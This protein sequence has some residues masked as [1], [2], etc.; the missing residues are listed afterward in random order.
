MIR[1]TFRSHTTPAKVALRAAL[2][3]GASTL[4]FRAQPAESPDSGPKSAKIDF[5]HSRGF[6]S[7]PFQLA[8]GDAAIPGEIRF[9]TDGSSPNPTNGT[10]YQKPIPVQ[11]TAVVRA[12]VVTQDGRVSRPQ[13]HT[14]LFPADILR[15][16]PDGLP[17]EGWPI[18]WGNNV[19]DYGMDPAV[20]DDPRYR[21]EVERALKSLPTISLVMDLADLFDA[22]TGIYANGQQGGRDWERPASVELIYPDGRKGFQEECGVRIR[23]GFSSGPFNP[24]HAFRLFFRREYG[25]GKLKYPMFGLDAAAEFDGF[26]MRCAQNYSWNIG[27]DARGLFVRDQFNRDLQRAMGQPAAR[28]DFYHL[29]LNGQY[30]GL[31]NSCE[32]PEASFAASYFGGSKEDYDVIKTAGVGGGPGAMALEATDGTMDRWRRL[33]EAASAD[34]SDNA[35][36]FKLLG[37]KPDGSPDPDG[38]ALLDPA[39]LIDYLLVIWFGGNLDA[40]VSRFAGNRAPNNW[41]AVSRRSPGD[42]F[43]FFIW[44]AE[45]TLLDVEEDRAGPFA[46]GGE[47]ADSS[48]PQWLFQRCV[49]N[50]EFRQLLA[51]R[52][53]QHFSPGGVLS[54]NFTI[55]L[56]KKHAETI[57]QAVICESARWGDVSGG[58]GFGAGDPSRRMRQG[59]D[60]EPRPV[61]RTRDA[62][63]RAEVD[64]QLQ[65]Y[66]PRR[67]DIVLFQLWRQGYVSDLQPPTFSAPAG[68]LAAGDALELSVPRGEVWF[69]MDGEDP[70]GVGGR[71][72][73]SAK[74]FTDRIDLE[75]RSSITART[76]HKGEWSP[77]VSAAYISGR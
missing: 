13:T 67:S 26:D 59:P 28:G 63:W 54:T 52:I 62:E 45:H 46:F 31:F 72:S 69:T 42:A 33:H 37:R 9:T 44:D 19:T 36:Y 22:E 20:V 15:Q 71:P 6:Y 5:S 24:K 14:Y 51:D 10:T 3:L 41:H 66:L 32:R 39:N 76:H 53:H 73:P 50:A 61:P 68:R 16:S 57:E 29:Y 25:A 18:A 70:R 75:G 8:L 77:R 60:G 40:P 56:L 27:G 17:P 35:A 74:R 4:A 64:R 43:R 21:E 2:V 1:P 65:D 49:E 23:G 34:L 11:E 12:S 7:S 30:W 38:D 47:Q 58:F 55:P 48:H